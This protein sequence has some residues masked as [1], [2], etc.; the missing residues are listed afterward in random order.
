MVSL[1]I[2][3]LLGGAFRYGYRRGIIQVTVSLS[4]YLLVFLLSI[5]LTKPVSI[6]IIDILAL[7][8]DNLI[9]GLFIKI[10]TFWLINIIGGILFRITQNTTKKI[11]KVKLISQINAIIGALFCSSIMYIFIYFGILLLINWPNLQLQNS[12]NE[13]FLAQLI[14]SSAQKFLFLIS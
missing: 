1:I 2:L 10:L 13:S 7:N 3:V 11:I 5:F 6:I 12:V 9:N 14:L 4:G 8:N